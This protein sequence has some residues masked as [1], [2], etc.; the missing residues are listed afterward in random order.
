ML[1]GSHWSLEAQKVLV[2]LGSPLC[3]S[4]QTCPLAAPKSHL[5]WV[6]A[7]PWAP[8]GTQTPQQRTCA[9]PY[10]SVLGRDAPAA[11]KS[12][13]KLLNLY[14]K[15]PEQWIPEE[16]SCLLSSPGDW[17]H[18]GSSWA[19]FEDVPCW[20]DHP[21]PSPPCCLLAVWFPRARS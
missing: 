7:A 2:A 4:A 18:G 15:T 1:Q 13:I 3:G 8:V 9:H 12:R 17:A 20:M 11:G 19:A 10:P 6:P 5:L 14:S 16:C 21:F